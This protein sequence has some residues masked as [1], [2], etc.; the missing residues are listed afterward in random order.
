M[1][2]VDYFN[3]AI[4]TNE[5]IAGYGVRARIGQHLFAYFRQAY[6][7][8]PSKAGFIDIVNNDII[9]GQRRVKELNNSL[10]PNYSINSKLNINARIRHYW[11]QVDYSKQ[12]TLQNDG[13]L[14]ENNHDIDPNKFDDNFNQFNI[15][16]LAKWQFA[17]ASEISLGYKLGNTFFNNDIRSSYLSNLKNTINENSSNTVSLKM[18]YF[19]D[20]NRFKKH[21]IF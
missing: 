3:S 11:I 13:D 21:R 6:E 8:K 2:L 14:V 1:V 4:Y 19:L 18:T 9:F 15:D 5:F 10:T 20:F 12:F 16:F 7:N 17:P